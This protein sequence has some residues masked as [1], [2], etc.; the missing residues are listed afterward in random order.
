[1]SHLNTEQME[2]IR[3]VRETLNDTEDKP[4]QVPSVDEFFD[5]SQDGAFSWKATEAGDWHIEACGESDC[6]V[7]WHRV[8]F[9]TDMGRDDQGRR[10]VECRSVDEDGDW[11][12]EAAWDEREGDGAAQWHQFYLDYPGRESNDFFRGWAQYWLHCAETRTDPAGDA[13]RKSPADP[14]WVDWC[15]KNAE[16]NIRYLSM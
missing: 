16:D 8:A 10:W 4:V 15:I 2:K 5:I 13:F 7:G 14:D 11:D 6:L 12:F 3:K 1:M 9:A